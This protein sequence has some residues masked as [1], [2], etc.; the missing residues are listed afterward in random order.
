LQDRLADNVNQR[1]REFVALRLMT[2]LGQ[3]F[4]NGR[5]PA[6]IFQLS[7][8]LGIPSRL[9]QS[10][11]RVLAHQQLVTEVA[12]PEAAFVPARPLE[13]INAYDILLALR[14]GTGQEL[15]L[16]EDP[17]LA[18]I[19]GEFARIE[20]AERAAA[21]TVSLLALTHRIAP[22]AV[23]PATTPVQ[24]EKVIA[25]AALPAESE[26]V[27]ATTVA[28]PTEATSPAPE[29]IAVRPPSAPPEPPRRPVAMPSENDFPL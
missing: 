5:R 27:A 9:T 21:S 12:G 1:G 11:L 15:P 3:R 25:P 19:Y 24:V 8:D 26:P 6:T 4:Q 22:P 17:A 14:T 18:E 7:T 29:K 2:C 13:T 20:Q 28:M 23:L 10:V 16:R